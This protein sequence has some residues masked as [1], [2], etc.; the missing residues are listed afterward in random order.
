MSGT[1][2]GGIKARLANVE[3]YGKDYYRIIGQKGGSRGKKHGTIKGFALMSPEKRSEAGR[4]G[5]RASRRTSVKNQ[6]KEPWW[7]RIF[8]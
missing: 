3:R 4:K 5:G 1:Y 6:P 7:K 8:G 2:A